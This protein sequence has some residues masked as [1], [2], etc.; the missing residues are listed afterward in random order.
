M[1]NTELIAI[2]FGLFIGY[3]VVSKLITPT[4]KNT[5]GFSSDNNSID[6]E[7][8]HDV[9]KV[10]PNATL[11]EIQAAYKTLI[12]QYHPDKVASLGNELIALAEEKS[13]AI[14]AAYKTAMKLRK[15]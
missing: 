14:N 13:K 10:S 4:T 11:D 1:S 9:L 2:A 15:Y 5:S 8:W 6:E 3:W 12:R 7:K